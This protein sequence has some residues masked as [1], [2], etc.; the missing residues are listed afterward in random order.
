MI[1]LQNAIAYFE[2]AC[3][4]VVTKQHIAPNHPTAAQDEEQP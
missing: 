4:W 2:I 3:I 1:I